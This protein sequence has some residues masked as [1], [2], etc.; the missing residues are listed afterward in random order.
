MVFEL[1][2]SIQHLVSSF[3]DIEMVYIF[4]SRRYKTGS[5]RSDI[6]LL[7]SSKISIKQSSLREFSIRAGSALDL[8]I[9]KNGT[10]T[11]VANESELFASSNEELINR[12]DAVLLYTKDIGFSEE[13]Q[14]WI[15]VELDRRAGFTMTSLPGTSAE[16]YEIRALIKYFAAARKNG[17]PEKPYLGID[18]IEAGEFIVQIL[19][20]ME[21]AN[22]DVKGNGRPKNSWNNSLADE[23]EFQNLFWITVKPWLPTL[24]R[25]G[26]ELKFDN[27]EKRSDFSLFENQLVIELKFIKDASDKREVVK[28]LDG[29]ANFYNQHPNTRMLI[30]GILVAKNVDLDDS[31][32]ETQYSFKKDNQETRT[33][34][35]RQLN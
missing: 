27:Q 4:G 16:Y 30:F 33:V 31:L 13:M 26:V 19:R 18:A 12:L 3:P 1:K 10:A 14:Q 28:T 17:L 23:T 22:S 11:S 7:I 29:L 2:A 15:S 24:C 8:F 32:W 21:S 20:R 9:L 35:I 5:T 25:E 6:D 34:I